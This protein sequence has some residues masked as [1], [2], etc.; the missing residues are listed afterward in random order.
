MRYPGYRVRVE[1]DGRAAHPAERRWRDAQRD[2]AAAVDGE[3]TL[4]Y[5]WTDTTENPCH[6]ARQIANVLRHNG[7]RASPHPCGPTCRLTDP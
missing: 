3:T 7:W 5:G 2:N 6:V 1:L 4:R